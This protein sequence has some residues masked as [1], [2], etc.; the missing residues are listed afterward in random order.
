MSKEEKEFLI[1][2]YLDQISYDFKKNPQL[3]F[4]TDE[5]I[6]EI[7]KNISLELVNISNFEDFSEQILE[8][9]DKDE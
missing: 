5:N 1:N 8:R 3:S 4:I 7:N 6:N 9:G 2:D